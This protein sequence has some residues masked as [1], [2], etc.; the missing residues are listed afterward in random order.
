YSSAWAEY[1]A[2]V[3][4]AISRTFSIIQCLR[5]SFGPL[6]YIDV[7]P[8]YASLGRARYERRDQYQPRRI[9]RTCLSGRGSAMQE[10]PLCPASE[11]TRYRK[12][13]RV[14]RW[15]TSANPTRT[16]YARSDSRYP[17]SLRRSLANSGRRPPFPCRIVRG[18][19][20]A[21]LRDEPFEDG[22]AHGA[23]MA[24]AY[25]APIPSSTRE[26]PGL[27]NPPPC[28]YRSLDLGS[29]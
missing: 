11:R 2:R 18:E 21:G 19:G 5:N 8:C 13:D 23:K 10:S 12:A 28:R 9:L 6:Q 16:G 3:A 29:L 14:G 24:S 25:S 22:V 4:R 17:R 7:E 20:L 27:P 15:I 26:G 1:A